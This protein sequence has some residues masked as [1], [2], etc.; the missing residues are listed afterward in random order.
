[1]NFNSWQFLVFFLVVSALYFVIAIFPKRRESAY[2]SKPIGVI[3]SNTLSRLLLL[4]SS[5]FFYAWWNPVYLGLMLFSVVVTWLSGILM[6]G[7]T[8]ERRK[9]ILIESLVL[10]LGILFFF[11]Y[12]NFFADTVNPLLFKMRLS[13]T[14]PAFS[15][16]LPVGISFYTFQALGYSI[17]VFRGTVTAERNFV[18]YALFV[19]FFPQLVAGPIERTGNLLPQFKVDHTFNYDRV[20]SGLKLATWGMFKKV[21]IAD[22][23]AVYVN[24]VYGE[25]GVYP[26]AAL[27]LATFF[28]TFQIYC[29]FSGY[30]DIAIGTARVLGFDLMTNFRRP[31]FSKSITE[32]WRCWHISLSTWLKDYIYIPL[33]GNRK[34]M[35]RQKLNL[36]FTFL[37]SGL[38][39]GAAWHFVIWGLLHGLF[40]VIERSI[41]E[42][43]SEGLKKIP[44]LQM[45]FTFLLVCL[46]WIFFRANTTR[47]AVLIIGKLTTLLAECVEYFALIPKQ[48][49]VGTARIAFQLGAKS[50]GVI[51]SIMGFGL[52]NWFF[53]MILIVILLFGDWWT[54]VIA[55]TK[56]VICLPLVI[57]WAGY[58][59]LILAIILNWNVD[60]SQFIYFTF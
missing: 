39:H 17:D 59:A 1:M 47:D 3:G 35:F 22:R 52:F 58:Y 45:G 16:L 5:L 51:H 40:Q 49:I 56:R 57:R 30:S 8:Q 43:V 36:L 18:S 15:V 6:A 21:V 28:F 50:Q 12:Y 60:T 54:K 10:N 19:T 37:L 53:S 46:A 26:A 55:E 24:T 42:R 13:A 32:F 33:G 23:I 14:F 31:Y 38:W 41:P 44:V 4:T 27:L 9:F 48:G 7:A 29:D 25:P 20:T 11:K 34:G 2:L